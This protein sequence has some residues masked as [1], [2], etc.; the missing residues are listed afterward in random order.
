MLR[1]VDKHLHF[2]NKVVM[3]Y[4]CGMGILTEEIMRKYKP[5]EVYACDTASESVNLT[6]ERCRMYQCFKDAYVITKDQ[7]PLKDGKFDII[8]VTEIVEHLSDE[9]LNF[10]LKQVYRLL[11]LGGYWL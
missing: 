2:D 9:A 1:V 7:L 8:F 10:L 6:K 5:R 3:D 11:K 4:G